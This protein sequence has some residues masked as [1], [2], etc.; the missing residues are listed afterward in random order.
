MVWVCFRGSDL[1]REEVAEFGIKR[2]VEVEGE[3]LFR[4]LGMT[5]EQQRLICSWYSVRDTSNLNR[6]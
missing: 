3:L 6:G 5:E 4:M 1:A 2:P